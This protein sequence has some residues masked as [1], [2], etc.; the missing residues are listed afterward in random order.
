[1]T[2]LQTR[3]IEP[4]DVLFLRGNTLF[5]DPGS[6]GEALIPPWPSLAAGALRSRILADAGVSLPAFARSEITHPELGTPKQPGSFAVT[7]FH[8]ARR[9][10]D[11]VEPLYAPPADLVPSRD[12]D[13]TLQVR[14]LHP[15]DPLRL[16]TR[17][18]LFSSATL[19]MLPVLAETQRC[20]PESGGWLTASGWRE[21]LAG[22]LP[23]AEQWLKSSELWS[24]DPRVG[25]G[26][27]TDARR[28]ADGKLFSMQAVAFQSGV[29]FLTQVS[30]A[31]LPEAGTLRLG[32]D[33]RAAALSP[34]CEVW[35]EPD[36]AAIA[37]AG[38]CRLVLTTPGLFCPPGT[39][40][41]SGGGWLPTGM[42]CTAEGDYAFD[43]HGVRARLVSAAIPRAEV[44]SG[45]DLAQW[46][47]KPAVKAAPT[48]A[49]YWLD[50]LSATPEALRRL[51]RQGLWRDVCEDP[52]RRAEG[53][54]RATVAA[55]AAG[56]PT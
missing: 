52:A 3:F 45:W 2:I 16:T 21:Y 48:G 29:G 19:P 54:N 51:I 55:W 27:D 31:H 36:Y 46:Q 53:F 4:L 17:A 39:E 1:M 23:A 9:V 11:Q 32:G 22:R 35:P 38:R 26:L 7:A 24:L 14:A 50:Q 18:S 6:Y 28:A 13:G 44:V 34:A 33:G 47:P 42:T 15:I 30:G 12:A 25:V 49:V 20:K 41:E 43:L 40:A 8:L 37:A 56:E 10:G 5:G